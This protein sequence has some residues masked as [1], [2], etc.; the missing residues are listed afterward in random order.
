MSDAAEKKEA[1][2][3]TKG[4]TKAKEEVIR[5]PK[6]NVQ[7]MVLSLSGDSALISH[8]WS[9]KAKKEMLDKQM[10]KAKQAKEAKNPAMD[11]AESLYLFDV[12]DDEMQATYQRIAD[13]DLKG[14]KF[15]FPAVAFKAAAVAACRFA[16]GIKMTEARGA[17]HVQGEL[18]EIE[19]SGPHMREDMVRI[20][21][22]TADIR[23]RGEFRDWK[24]RL[25]IRYNANAWSDHPS[26]CP[27]SRSGKRISHLTRWGSAGCR[28]LPGDLLLS[29]SNGGRN[30]LY[31][32]RYLGP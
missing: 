32:H 8:R 4:K 18:I 20:G 24:A 10:K 14:I 13:G 1:P 9:E 11:F 30:S 27:W 12:P 23:Y 2:K 21:M 28:W 29:S 15:G 22:G 16:D 7:T 31:P 25:V 17:F 3:K 5:L 19:T 6:L 26:G